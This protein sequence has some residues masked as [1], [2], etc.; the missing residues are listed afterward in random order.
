MQFDETRY[1]QDFLKKL[2][3]A[4]TLPDDLLERYAITLPATE[5]EISAQLKAVRAYW[6]K[7]SSGSTYAAQAAKMCRAED[8]RLRAQYG[9]NMEKRGWWEAQ[10]AARRSAAQE[11]VTSLA[12]ELRRTYGELGV[13][14]AGAVDG[15]AAKL[16]LTQAD[17]LQ[18]VGQAGLTLADG[19]KLP[20]SPPL[21]AASFEALLKYMSEC[22]VSS[23][24]EL[25]HPGAGP[26]TL[27][28]R[29]V[30]TGDPGRR[31]DAVAVEAQSAE[32][33]KRGV[34]ATENARR[35]A[36]KIL[37]R[38]AKDGVDLREI[39]LYHLV[40]VA[41]E[42]LPPSMRMA[43]AALQKA[44]L[45]RWDA[46]VIAVLLGDQ[47]A[48]SSAAGLGKVRSLLASAR[49]NE[50]RQS[51]LNLPT[52]ATGRE[53]AL[54]EV[55]AARERLAVLLAEVRQAVQVPDESHAAT[56]LREIAA[57]SIE[58]AEAERAAVPLAPPSGPR[59]VCDGETVKLFWQP[60][61]GP[62][63]STTYVVTRTE[64]RP[65]AAPGD[66]SVVY[67]GQAAACADPHAPVARVAQYGIF[68]LADGRPGSRPAIVAATLLPP[69]SELEA[70]VGPSEI[71]VHWSA[72]PAAQEVRVTRS[73]QGAPPAPVAV[74]G[75]NCRLTGLPEG[76]AQ[77]FE[78]TAIYRGRSGAEMLSAAVQIN[79]TPM[80]EAQPIPRLRARPV[81]VGGAVRVRVSWQPVDNSEVRIM[82]SD[83][84]PSW[85]FGTWVRQEEMARFG[86]EV[87]GRRTI[88]GAETAIEADLPPGVHHLVPFSIGGTGIVMG[89]P[90]TV[91]VTDPVRHLVVTPFA[92]YATVSWEWPAMAQ[93][94]EV[95]WTADNYADCVVMGQAQYRSQGGARVPLGRGPCT[96]EVRAMIVV[97][98]DSFRSPPVQKVVDAAADVAIRYAVSAGPNLG[99]FG[100]RS[101]RVAF[102]CDEGCQGVRVRMVALPGR[103]MPT[104]AE[105][106]IVLLDTALALHPGVPVEHQ[107]T[108]P[109]AVKRPYWVRCF[110][111]GG[112]ARL[113]DP[114]I[115]ALKET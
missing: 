60:A 109:R 96:I 102:S 89:R 99:P 30:C 73:A 15:F 21:P 78:V 31:L 39:A 115:S 70:D 106:A 37:R 19:V 88:A 67:R 82:H 23:V 104:R 17:A 14:T 68:A 75:N 16:G 58:D 47:S 43:A 83:V 1:A 108:V 5:P 46:A 56:L 4:R 27:I 2:R 36:L 93:L 48:A 13:V 107:V 112:Q 8:E 90:V 25:V 86:R 103:V 114:P 53:E 91:G 52:G 80:S 94:A 11:S 7:V 111:V 45:E 81:D 41:E 64:Q 76:Q 57:I 72:H 63:E 95:S 61:A 35:A 51:A 3:G 33:D 66:G 77:H 65:P 12:E 42:Y 98:D 40:K 87:S 55:E 85:Q 32:A 74:T 101:K 24:P 113:I 28:E 62:D 29:Y 49:L 71:T 9:S 50:A 84:P 22:A 10:Q 92:T 6:N 59:A 110:V 79:A 105:G 54:K 26:F 69:V 18:A 100:G 34:S 44:G 20:D 97:G 38:A